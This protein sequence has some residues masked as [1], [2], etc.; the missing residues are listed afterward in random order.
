MYLWWLIDHR[1]FMMILAQQSGREVSTGK[2]PR[3]KV[4]DGVSLQA[5]I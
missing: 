3:K 2:K 5:I 4:M 1:T